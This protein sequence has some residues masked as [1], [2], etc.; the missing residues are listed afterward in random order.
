[1]FTKAIRQNGKIYYLFRLTFQDQGQIYRWTA[2][3]GSIVAEYRRREA[4][5]DNFIQSKV[6]KQVLP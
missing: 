2:L 6:T 3:N 1:M 5:Y 4:T